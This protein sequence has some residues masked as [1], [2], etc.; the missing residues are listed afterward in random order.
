MPDMEN[1][2]YTVIQS[3]WDI[4]SKSNVKAGLF[5]DRVE[6]QLYLTYFLAC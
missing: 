2:G 4:K 3:G 1:C 6:K 5:Y